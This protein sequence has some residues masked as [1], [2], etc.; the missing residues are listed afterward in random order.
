MEGKK[1]FISTLIL[2]FTLAATAQASPAPGSKEVMI[3]IS[4]AFVPDVQ[5]VNDDAYLVASGMFPNSCYSW[6]H[7]EVR[8]V[9]DFDH[10][11]RSFAWVSS[12]PCLMYLVPFNQEIKMGRLTAGTHR[13]RF[14]SHDDTFL[15]KRLVVR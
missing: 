10:E 1:C 5:S 3:A 12:G 7:A 9:T 6:S 14:L 2:M 13:I 15:E 4:A 8:N 11:I